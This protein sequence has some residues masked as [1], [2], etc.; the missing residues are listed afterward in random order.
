M[1]LSGGP[2][3][4]HGVNE[5]EVDLLGQPFRAGIAKRRWCQNVTVWKI[6]L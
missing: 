1:R 2:G 4:R 3:T 6:F 5:Q